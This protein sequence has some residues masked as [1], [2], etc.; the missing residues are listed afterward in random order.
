[1]LLIPV[2]KPLNCNTKIINQMSGNTSNSKPRSNSLTNEVNRTH[3]SAVRALFHDDYLNN[4]AFEF[5]SNFKGANTSVQYKSVA[6][7]KCGKPNCSFALTDEARLDF[8]LQRDSVF[9][10]KLKPT[11]ALGHLDLGHH[12]YSKKLHNKDLNFWFN[13]Y[14]QYQADRSLGDG[15][16]YIGLFTHLNNNLFSMNSRVKLQNKETQ[17]EGELENNCTVKYNNLSFNC[18][19]SGDLQNWCKRVSRK[20]NLEYLNDKLSVAA[21]VEKNTKGSCCDWKLDLLNVGIAYQHNKDLTYGL[22]SA[23]NLKKDNET[24]VSAGVNYKPTSDLSIKAKADTNQDVSLFTNYNCAKGL[25]LQLSVQ[26]SLDSER[27]KSVFNNAFK[28]GAKLKYD[29]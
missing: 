1:M 22:W 25:N 28:F 4:N 27:F 23:T 15:A 21:E 16:L 6:N 14:I 24:V 29:C 9:R 19:Y 11:S 26:S 2:L 7:I 13:P 17:I 18:Y 10:L 12:G 5:E 3:K 8:K 20:I